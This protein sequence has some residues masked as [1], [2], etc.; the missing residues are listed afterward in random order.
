VSEAAAVIRVRPRSSL[1]GVAVLTLLLVTA[2]LAGV[3]YWFAVARG[4]LVPTAVGHAAVLLVGVAVGVRQ[5]AV[6]TEVRDGRLRGNGI[7]TPMVQVDL[8]RIAQ[9]DIVATY[10]GLRPTP[11]QQ[12]LVRDAEGR[13]LYRLRGNFW[14]EGT[15]ARVA[16]ALPVPATVVTEPIDLG[17][18]FGRYPGSAYWFENRPAVFAIGIALGAAAVVALA[19]GAVMLSGEPFAL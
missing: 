17:D 18:F 13:R 15:L 8:A 19:A 2:P 16:A 1:L 12:L 6:V 11:V 10:V 3:A 4:L 14:P 9:V 7:F 5:L